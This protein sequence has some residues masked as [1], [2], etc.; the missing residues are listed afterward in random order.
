[1]IEVIK[2]Y[3]FE[4][5]NNSDLIE[6]EKTIGFSLPKNYLNFLK[7]TNGGTPQ[8]NSLKVKLNNKEELWSV[9][10]FFGVHRGEYWASIF[11]VLKALNNR[12]PKEFFPFANNGGGD[13]Y[14]INLSTEKYGEISIWNHNTESKNNGLK[15]YKNIRFLYKSFDEFSNNLIKDDIEIEIKI[16]ETDTD[17]IIE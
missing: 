16:I 10:Y 8:L 5:L 1:M 13:Y 15:Y 17:F 7:K 12:I 2:P 11:W 3:E 4:R 6:L 9:S 14:V